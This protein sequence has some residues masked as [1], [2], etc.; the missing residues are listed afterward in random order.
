M[1]NPNG[2]VLLDEEAARAAEERYTVLEAELQVMHTRNEE[3]ACRLQEQEEVV[4]AE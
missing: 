3:L 4:A 2:Q 1:V